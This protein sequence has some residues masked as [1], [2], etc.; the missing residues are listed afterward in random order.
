[1]TFNVEERRR[2][3]EAAFEPWGDGFVYYKNRWAQGIPVSASERDQ[4]LE[5]WS[6]EAARTFRRRVAGRAP[7]VP[8][9]GAT[10]AGQS[11][12]GLLGSIPKR[13]AVGPIAS[14]LFSVFVLAHIGQD[15]LKLVAIIG[16]A[17]LILIGLG[18]AMVGR[19]SSSSR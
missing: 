17:I 4:Y 9:R 5:H 1:M 15:W 7:V 10:N 6:P 8:A 2:I 19:R 12:L 11:R 14:G 16:G 3:L 18:I 13:A